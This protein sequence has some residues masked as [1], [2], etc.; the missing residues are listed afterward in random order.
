MIRK[1]EIAEFIMQSRKGVIL[2]VRSPGEYESGHIPGAIS[3][4]LFD[5]EERKT[6]GI[7]YKEEGKQEA[8][9]NGLDIVGPKMSGFVKRAHELSDGKPLFLHCWRGGMRSESL[10]W[11][12]QTA[13]FKVYVL[14]GGYKAY[15]R[16]VQAALANPLNILILGGKTGSGKTAILH[17]L[18]AEGEQI[19]DLE[20]LAN[21]KGSVFGAM[22]QDPQPTAEQFEN[23]LYQA[24]SR[25][26]PA[27]IVW[28]EDESASI[29]KVFIPRP[30]WK[31]MNAAR[32]IQVEVPK[33][34]RIRRLVDEYADFSK[35]DL[36]EALL[37]IRKRLQNLNAALKAVEDGDFAKTAELSLAYYDRA[38]QTCL[39]R[40]KDNLLFSIDVN[41]DPPEQIARKLLSHYYQ[42][43]H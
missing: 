1:A 11:L 18:Q 15:R 42:S 21:H 19:V 25:L 40:K 26:D 6:I 38:Y 8:L 24:V 32:V 20:G 35:T 28:I 36:S 33:A 14:E 12:L 43:V 13:G 10:A 7:L 9:L 3:F 5:N 39:D 37:R 34:E 22:G 4:P 17:A 2:D 29:G 23:L 16:F 30:F 41:A 31:Q 27:R